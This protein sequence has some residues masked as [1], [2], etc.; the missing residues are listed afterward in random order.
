MTRC[1]LPSKIYL[2]IVLS[3]NSITCLQPPL[4]DMILL[5]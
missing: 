5:K 1:F 2:H 4:F 3:H